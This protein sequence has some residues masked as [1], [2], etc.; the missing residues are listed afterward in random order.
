MSNRNIDIEERAK[1]LGF[2][3]FTSFV[4]IKYLGIEDTIPMRKCSNLLKMSPNKFRASIIERGWRPKNRSQCVRPKPKK[5]KLYI[6]KI[7]RNRTK[8]HFPWCCIYVYYWRYEMTTYEVAKALGVSQFYLLKL[9]KKYGI[10]RRK[11]GG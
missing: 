11:Q 1:N 2:R 7:V 3:N 9:M 8:F 10:K 4:F 6:T 5:R